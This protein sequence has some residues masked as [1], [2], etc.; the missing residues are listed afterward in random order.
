MA[1][2]SSHH[3]Y[4]PYPIATKTLMQYIELYC[5]RICFN[6]EGSAFG[7]LYCVY[8]MTVYN[9]NHHLLYVWEDIQTHKIIIIKFSLALHQCLNTGEKLFTCST[10]KKVFTQKSRDTL[11][12][13]YVNR[14]LLFIVFCKFRPA[15]L[16]REPHTHFSR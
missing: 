14:Q 8:D 12:Q 7:K 15:L 10:C 16:Q 4:K 1:D 2:F 9:R 13:D 3:E 6:L 11:S 5:I